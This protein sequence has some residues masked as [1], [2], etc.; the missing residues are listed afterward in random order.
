MS[1]D[2]L[3]VG[4]TELAL[5]LRNRPDAA[6]IVLRVNGTDDPAAVTAEVVGAVAMIAEVEV[7]RATA[8]SDARTLV[9]ALTASR[10]AVVV[11]DGVNSFDAVQWRRFDWLRSRLP[12]DVSLVLV[13]DHAS[14]AR[15][16]SDAPNL[17][18]WMNATYTWDAHADELSEA[19]RQTRLTELERWSGSTSA[20]IV[21][22]AERGELP[23]DA[24]YRDWLILL[25][26][27]D[28]LA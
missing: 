14:A 13:L 9:A 15:L 21:A 25:D 1:T 8:G 23:A 26:R 18:S 7:E 22:R 6:R 28:L 27:G 3:P 11:V 10:A 12:T 20:E 2:L 17:A 19:E 5:R 24:R 4:A 16:E